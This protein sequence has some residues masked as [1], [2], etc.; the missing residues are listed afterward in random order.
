MGVGVMRVMFVVLAAL[1]LPGCEVIGN[2][3]QAGVVV[4]VL[5]VI[6]SVALLSFLVAQVRRRV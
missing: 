6:A 1:A 3:F 2:I 5:L 4:G